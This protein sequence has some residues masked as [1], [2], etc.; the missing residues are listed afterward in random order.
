MTDKKEHAR[1]ELI[2]N[3]TEDILLAL[4]DMDVSKKELAL[5]L[6]KSRSYVSQAL[7]GSRNMTLGS[8]SDIYYA[9]GVKPK[10]AITFTF[11]DDREPDND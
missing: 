1:E 8:L 5:S 7:S 9:L 3:I 4:E 6:G 11:E 2:Y 10:V